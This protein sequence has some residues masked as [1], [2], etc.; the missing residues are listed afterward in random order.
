MKV[1]TNLVVD[2][3]DR[4]IWLDG[5]I[6]SLV[7]SR[8]VKM[9]AKLNRLE[10]SPIIFY[11]KGPG[12][13]PY[14]TFWMMSEIEASA[15]PVAIVAHEYVNSACFTIT[16]AGVHRLALKGTRFSFHPVEFDISNNQ[17]VIRTT[18]Q[19]LMGVLDSLRLIDAMQLLWFLK[20][21]R[22]VKK[23]M[24]LF[25]ED[26]TIGLSKAR[27]LK[28]IDD[29][30]EESDFLKDKRRAMKLIKTQTS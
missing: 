4:F 7:A 11:I 20:R 14:P 27:K 18:Q 10:C 2:Y 24:R 25:I 12:G 16:Q 26:S 13:N 29:Y 6:T 15:S 1:K 5:H 30:Y 17:K 21:S 9:L 22:P 8:F 3:E 28:I 19:E 23:V